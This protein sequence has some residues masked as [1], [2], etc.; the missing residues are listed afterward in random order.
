MNWY[1]LYTMSYKTSKIVS[2]L[3]RHKDL[4]AFIPEYEVCNHKTKDIM[5]KPMFRNY[6]FVKTKL[7]QNDFNDLL[8]TMKEEN[9][10]LIKQLKNNQTSALTADEIKFF[11][12]VLD[13][14][15][16]VRLSHGY[17][18]N[19][20]TKVT[21]GPLK[22]YEEHIVKVD[23]HNYYAYLDLVFFDRRILLGIEITSKN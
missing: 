4:I 15:Y 2:N 7:N 14:H 12:L 17:Q 23:K 6:I 11:S 21:D 20:I 5:I 19:G 8:L 1:V 18:E 9:D 3:N 10:G 16:I 13:E 22:L